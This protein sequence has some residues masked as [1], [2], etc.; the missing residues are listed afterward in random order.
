[1]DSR[2]HEFKSLSVVTSQIGQ[3]FVDSHLLAQSLANRELSYVVYFLDLCFRHLGGVCHGGGGGLLLLLSVLAVLRLSIVAGLAEQSI[4]S[5]LLHPSRALI[6]GLVATS[7]VRKFLTSTHPLE[8]ARPLNLTEYTDFLIESTGDKGKELERA[9]EHDNPVVG[10][11]AQSFMMTNYTLNTCLCLTCG[12][13]REGNESPAPVYK[14]VMSLLCCIPTLCCMLVW[15]PCVW[16]CAC[17]THVAGR[18]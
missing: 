12:L 3:V 4:I 11:C 14:A 16:P 10:C 9:L 15:C 7:R 8:M 2:S 5:W 6:P 13:P 1:M 18:E 17:V